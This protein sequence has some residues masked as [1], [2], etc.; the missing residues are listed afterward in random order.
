MVIVAITVFQIQHVLDLSFCNDT[1]NTSSGIQFLFFYFSLVFIHL[2][3]ISGNMTLYTFCFH[4]VTVFCL[5]MS[6][7]CFIIFNKMYKTKTKRRTVRN[8]PVGSSKHMQKYFTNEKS[9]TDVFV[10]QIFLINFSK[11]KNIYNILKNNTSGH[12]NIFII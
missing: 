11:E 8:G 5:Q 6:C 12:T 4:I 10:F 7:I 3:Y 1:L 9:E 2:H